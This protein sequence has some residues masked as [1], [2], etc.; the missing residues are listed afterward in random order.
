M[1][2]IEN[3]IKNNITGGFKLNNTKGFAVGLGLNLMSNLVSNV[4]SNIAQG[5]HD[6]NPNPAKYRANQYN[7]NGSNFRFTPNANKSS[8]SVLGGW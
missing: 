3:Y 8:F 1:Q 4:T 7:W 5:I 6:E 2:K